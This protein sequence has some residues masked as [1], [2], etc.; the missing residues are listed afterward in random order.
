[1]SLSRVLVLACCLALAPFL[2]PAKEYRSLEVKREF[3]RQH[4]CPSTG[5]ATGACPGYIKDHIVPLACGGPDAV[6]NMQ[7]TNPLPRE[8]VAGMLAV[9]QE[10]SKRVD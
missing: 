3:Q 9:S 1:M 6:S 7:R 5:R 8:K 2:A 10:D 4:P